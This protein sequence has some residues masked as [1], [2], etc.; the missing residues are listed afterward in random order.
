MPKQKTEFD[1]DL[2]REIAEIMSETDLTEVELKQ[3]DRR[4]RLSRLTGAPTPVAAAPVA[5]PTA[6][7]ARA[8]EEPADSADSIEDHPGMVSSPMVGTAYLSPQPGDDPFVNVG[9]RVD[10]GQTLMIIEAMKVMN[11]IPAPR[12]GTVKAI[13]ISD[14]QPVE[15][16]DPLAIIE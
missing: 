13:L 11:P 5:A 7:P 15:F 16:G 2:V 9:A 8:A 12:A 10:E 3:G 4:L 6:Q 1:C 14:A